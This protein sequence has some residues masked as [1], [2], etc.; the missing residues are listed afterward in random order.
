MQT[1]KASFEKLIREDRAAREV[2]SWR[3]SFLDYLDLVREDIT[4]PRLSHARIHDVITR[5]GAHDVLDTEDPRVS[6]ARIGMA[7]GLGG[8]E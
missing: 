8:V 6:V 1:D 7:C 2:R 5:T 3:G 4:I